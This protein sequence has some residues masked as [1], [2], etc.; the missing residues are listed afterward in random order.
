MDLS[1]VKLIIFDVGGVVYDQ[2]SVG[3]RVARELGLSYRKFMEYAAL[4]GIQGLQLGLISQEYFMKAFQHLYHHR[5]PEDLWTRFFHPVPIPETID[6]IE[7]LKKKFRVVAGTNTILPHYEVHMQRGDYGIFPKVYASNILHLAKPD[8]RFYSHIIQAEAVS[9]AE[10]LF[11][12]DSIQNVETA[13]KLGI[14]A[15][16]FTGGKA[17]Q[18]ALSSL[19]AVS[20]AP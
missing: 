20:F 7:R 15:I 6:A 13:V 2:T 17:L 10:S 14:H 4:S 18:E 16:L 3:R 19:L 5:S 9:A 8:P 11:I 1:Q 12:D